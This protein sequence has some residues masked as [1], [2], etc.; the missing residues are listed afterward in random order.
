MEILTLTIRKAST[1]A[2]LAFDLVGH[3]LSSD[4]TPGTRYAGS[5]SLG[6]STSASPSTTDHSTRP[7][8]PAGDANV[9]ATEQSSARDSP[10]TMSATAC[11]RTFSA[12]KA[13][14]TAYENR[15]SRPPRMP[16]DP[17]TTKLPSGS[18]EIPGSV[19]QG[20]THVCPEGDLNPHA[21]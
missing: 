4:Y 18:F 12:P 15:N 21:R 19:V 7:P 17:G 14:P 1:A 9:E 13:G 10:R 8:A 2:L 6:R 16:R 11:P 3:N 5:P 20:T